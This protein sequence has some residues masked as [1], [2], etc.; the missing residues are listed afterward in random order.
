M[1]HFLPPALTAMAAAG[2]AVPFARGIQFVRAE[3]QTPEQI[4][5]AIQKTF[6]TFKAENDKDM[7]DIKKKLGDVV[8][9]E[10]VDRINATIG[11]MVKALDEANKAIAALQLGAGGEGGKKKTSA[12]AKEHRK[13]FNQFFRKGI[14]AG[15]RELEVKAALRTDSEADGGFLVPEEDAAT[16]DRILGTVSAMRSIAQ[17]VT[18]GAA[19]YKK[20]VG[21][22]GTSSGWVGERQTRTETNTPTL[23]ELEFPAMEIYANPAITQTMLD[24][25]RIDVAQWLGDEVS[26]EFAEQEGAAFISGNGV[27]RPRGILSYDTV[28]NASYAWGKLGFLVT[29][30]AADIN[31]GSNNG[32]DGLINVLYAIKQGYRTDARWLMNRT[33][34]GKVRKLKD[35]DSNYLWTPPQQGGVQGPQP[36]ML[37]GYPIV[38]DDNMPDVGANTFPVAFGNFRRGYLIVDRFGI[39][40]LRDPYTNKPYVHFYT[41]KRVGGG[42]Q[43]FEA[44]KLLKCST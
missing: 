30:V 33:L 19:T 18:V 43:N 8:Q 15:L 44:I 4:L 13:A 1:K 10:K 40:V 28:A 21:L 23:A 31:D 2:S 22:G 25:G 41:T 35:G 39:R 12:E 11:D 34:Q 6:E 42:V 27:L 32:I 38:D 26:I 20:L 24:D 37:L 36:A 3:T 7:A 17:V 29:G 14:E 9:T 5:A 16:I